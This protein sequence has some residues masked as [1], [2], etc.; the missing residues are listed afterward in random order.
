MYICY[1][2]FCDCIAVDASGELMTSTAWGS[3][4]CHQVSIKEHS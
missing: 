4:A 1:V 2:F 3:Q